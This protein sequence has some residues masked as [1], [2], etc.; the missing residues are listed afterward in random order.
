VQRETLN[1][2]LVEDNIG[3]AR[4]IEVLLAEEAGQ[5]LTLTHVMRLGDAV[6]KL[7]AARYDVVLLDLSLPD[8]HGL[9]TVVA[10]RRQAGNIP[11][12]VLSG[13]DNE[14]VALRA[15]QSGA[16]DYLVKGRA[17]GN[18]IKRSIL[19]ALERHRIRQR[20]LLAEA[21]FSATDT[22]IIVLDV[23]FRIIRVNP[24]FT[25]LTGFDVEDVLNQ[26]PFMLGSGEHEPNYH[27]QILSKLSP[28]DG[29]EGE[30]WNRRK[31]GDVFPVWLRLNAVRDEGETLSGYV[32][33]L[34]DITH[35]KQVEAELVRQATRD[36]LTGL[37]NRSLLRSLM[38]EVVA[39]SAQSSSG[40]AFL[41]VD[42]DGFKAVN[43]TYGHDVGDELLKDAARRLRAA[44]RA[45]D[46]VGRLGGDEFVVLLSDVSGP[47]DAGAVAAK[48]VG[49]LS[50]PFHIGSVVASVSASVGVAVFPDDGTVA[51]ALLKTADEAMYDAKNSGKNQWRGPRSTTSGASAAL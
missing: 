46:E 26:P 30:V 9:E 48:I 32:A 39:R 23:N 36:A 44:L 12:V 24:A 21:A 19:Y 22:G 31:G 47:A 49:A 34:S 33:V 37:P 20:V 42:L 17:D 41:F 25:R 45:S 29:W 27:E 11:V 16:E 35:R 43:D 51:E 8:S 5:D 2:L 50:E 6:E 10:L 1:I 3:D 14:Q 13:M 15:L 7:R 18:L 38:H 28:E 40:C 4:L